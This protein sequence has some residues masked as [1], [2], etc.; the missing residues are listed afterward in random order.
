MCL[1]LQPDVCAMASHDM[2]IVFTFWMQPQRWTLWLQRS[3]MNWIFLPIHPFSPSQRRSQSEQNSVQAIKPA[4][5]LCHRLCQFVILNLLFKPKPNTNKQTWQHF[6]LSVCSRQNKAKP[7]TN[8]QM[9]Q[10]HHSCT[11]NKQ[12]QCPSSKMSGMCSDTI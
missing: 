12:T 7:N 11:D 10:Q 9:W 3:L 2:L 5:L 8:K 1:T 6:L 4:C